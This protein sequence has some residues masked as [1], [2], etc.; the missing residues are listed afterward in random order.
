M[1]NYFETFKQT[2]MHFRELIFLFLKLNS[3]SSKILKIIFNI[4]C[5]HKI[6]ILIHFQ[7]L[8]KSSLEEEEESAKIK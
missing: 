5:E 6:K 2:F 3:T 1:G 7:W 8:I 4:Q